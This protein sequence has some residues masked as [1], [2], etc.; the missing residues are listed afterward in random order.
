VLFRN[1][2]LCIGFEVFAFLAHF[3]IS[4]D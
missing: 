3:G 1:L 4:Q 2:R